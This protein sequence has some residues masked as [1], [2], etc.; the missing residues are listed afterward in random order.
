ME[1]ERAGVALIISVDYKPG[2]II[3]CVVLVFCSLFLC[4]IMYDADPVEYLRLILHQFHFTENNLQ[5]AVRAGL[6]CFTKQTTSHAVIYCNQ[7]VTD[8]ATHF[9]LVSD[10]H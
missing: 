2:N 8:M 3:S 4:C 6:W 7:H 1:I 5:D 10:T 9:F